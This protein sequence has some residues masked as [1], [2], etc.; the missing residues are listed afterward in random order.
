MLNACVVC[1]LSSDIMELNLSKRRAKQKP[2]VL[3]RN[4][5]L[6][7]S[8]VLLSAFRRESGTSVVEV[9][10]SEEDAS[11]ELNGMVIN[12]GVRGILEGKYSEAVDRVFRLWLCWL[13]M[14]FDTGGLPQKHV[15]ICCT[16][17]S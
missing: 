17:S 6:P 8:S 10:F 3:I 1:V 16:R 14:P 7:G 11:S 2:L 12:M 13:I 9:H 15:Y 5:V 4:T